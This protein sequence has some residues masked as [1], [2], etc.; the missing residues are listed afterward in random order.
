MGQCPICKKKY[1]Q[2]LEYCPGC[3]VGVIPAFNNAVKGKRS[4]FVE[5]YRTE[6][7]ALAGLIKEVME[8]HEVLSYLGNYFSHSLHAHFFFPVAYQG[9]KVMVYYEDIEKARE[10]LNLFFKED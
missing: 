2:D 1:I 7:V 6:N 10:I 4:T 3:Q 5:V 8:D 9:I